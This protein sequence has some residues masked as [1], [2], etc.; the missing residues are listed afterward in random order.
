MKISARVWSKIAIGLL[1]VGCISGSIAWGAEE[2]KVVNK[3][4]VKAQQ[5]GQWNVDARIVN[6]VT[7]PI[8]VNILAKEI[9]QRTYEGEAFQGQGLL[10]IPIEGIPPGKTLVVESVSMSTLQCDPAAISLIEI[11]TEEGARV[12]PPQTQGQPRI[13]TT[14]NLRTDL[15]SEFD[16]DTGEPVGYGF[17]RSN[18]LRTRFYLECTP[19]IKV[20][21]ATDRSVGEPR[22]MQTQQAIVTALVPDDTDDDI[23]IPDIDIPDPPPLFSP[24]PVEEVVQPINS[25]SRIAVTLMGYLEPS[26][27]DAG[28]GDDGGGDDGGFGL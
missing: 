12:H 1:A 15:C 23:D 16:E 25:S 17:A 19:T 18:Y 9:F 24:P 26:S 21:L 27:G 22:L 6:D 20:H 28:C 11:D 8:P 4:A 3:P 2:V 10:E 14:G 13:L 5:K 7:Q